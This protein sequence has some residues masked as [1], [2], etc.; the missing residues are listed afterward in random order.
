MTDPRIYQKV[1]AEQKVDRYADRIAELEAALLEIEKILDNMRY[2]TYERYA[3][4]LV[5]NKAL[6]RRLL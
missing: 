6:N 5:I 4:M 1:A 3:S 2:P